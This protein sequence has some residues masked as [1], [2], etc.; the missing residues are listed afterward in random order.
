MNFAGICYFAELEGLL[1]TRAGKIN[2]VI[3]A[4]KAYPAPYISSDAF[5]GI[6]IGCD[7]DPSSLTEREMRYVNSAIK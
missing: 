1:P 4:V 7:I 5:E 2:K 3:K 6:L